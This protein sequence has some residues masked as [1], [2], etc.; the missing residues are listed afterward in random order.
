A[1]TLENLKNAASGEKYEWTTMY[2]EFEKVARE[3]GEAEIADFFKEVAEVEEKH[4][5]RYNILTDLLE[6]GKMF[7]GDEEKEWKCL[8]CGYIHKGTSA[9]EKCPVCQKK[10]GWYMQ[11]GVVR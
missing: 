11:L 8:N 2:P 3:E 1:T 6:S 5:E 7:K 9:P 10:Q 4:E